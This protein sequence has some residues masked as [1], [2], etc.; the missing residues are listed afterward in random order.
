M[1]CPCC[2]A[3]VQLLELGFFPC[4]PSRPTI[5]FHLDLLQLVT[6][7][8]RNGVPNITAWAETLDAFWRDRGFIIPFEGT[9]R[10]RLA[11]ALQWYQFLVHQANALVTKSA[12]ISPTSPKSSSD[13]EGLSPP[14][15]PLNAASLPLLS[16]LPSSSAPTTLPSAP[17]G[18]P[19]LA[20]PASPLDHTRSNDGSA[21]T[22]DASPSPPGLGHTS[23]NTA[24]PVFGPPPPLLRPD[25]DN[26]DEHPSAYLRARCP[27]CF[28]GRRPKMSH[29]TCDAHACLDAC[30]G[31]KRRAG[32]GLDPEI[33][34]DDSRFLPDDLVRKMMER[35]EK[36]RGEPKKAPQKREK[37]AEFSG[38]PVS[39][40]V[41]D[42][43]E[44]TFIAA[45][46]NVAKSSKKFYS[47][48]GLMA[49][50]CRHDR[51]LWLVNLTTP[52]EQ[53]HYA[54]ALI[55]QLFL[56]LPSFWRIGLLYDIAC[57]LHR[58]L[59]KWDL[60]PE[61]LHRLVFG[62]SVFHAY[63]HQ[64]PC[65]LVY[66]PR[67][68]TEFG[69]T[70]GEGCERF[71]Y[72][73]SPLIPSL[74]VSGFYRRL[75]VLDCQLIH[76]EEISLAR[77]GAWL[78][79]RSH[80]CKKRLE[81]AVANFKKCGIDVGILRSQWCAQVKAQTE[82]AP[83]QSKN[84]ADRAVEKVVLERAKLE[85]T[86]AA[87]DTL[88]S[89]L[90]AIPCEQEQ[91]REAVELDLESARATSAQVNASLKAMEKAL[92]VTGKQQLAALKGNP[93]LRA[94]MNA[95]ALRARIRARIIE[96]K[97]ERTKIERAFRRQMQQEKNH[98]HTNASIHR[99]KGSIMT[100]IRK[101]NKLVDDMK[102]L[103]RDGQAPIES[104]L[105]RTLDAAKI[106]RLDVDDDLWQDDPGLGDD[107][108]GDVPGWLGNDK[109]RDGIVAMLERD[110]CFEEEE[111]LQHERGSMQA[112]ITSEVRAITAACI[113]HQGAS[114]C[115]SLF[116]LKL[117]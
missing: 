68:R 96:H 14:P 31:H 36:A 103:R 19:S 17:P 92:G 102:A 109:I 90:A 63:G 6:L 71:W 99:R 85:D 107:D 23:T 9:L 51:V 37:H 25:D 101:F 40:S 93:Y 11:N 5:A 33:P 24:R 76:L 111:R 21:G 4:A 91:A 39:N 53:Q 52:G 45:Q 2:S 22:A 62:V 87:I 65:Q 20:T 78:V 13:T 55:V 34:Y 42:H 12:D 106:F 84:I 74:R 94:R 26:N 35:V 16:R 104:K 60:L 72:A 27:L 48:T 61:Y 110:R 49:L 15:T 116:C 67:K 7:Q 56:H 77:L 95:R 8:L 58:S 115:D 82:K 3:G 1:V 28:G 59:V 47:D 66:H 50:L 97:F 80:A 10:R 98:A 73:I 81:Q 32:H 117:S 41:L 113:V 38:L 86:A 100:L 29:S 46:E 114:H 44:A 89:R 57:Q 88:E 43:C 70:D 105:P 112:W 79:R 69:L 18:P 83:R 108:A 64:W 54:L 30:F 75:F